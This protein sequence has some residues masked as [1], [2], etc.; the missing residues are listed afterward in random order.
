MG[1]H[2][3]GGALRMSDWLCPVGAR[4]NLPPAA[5]E[6]G[7]TPTWRAS[8]HTRHTFACCKTSIISAQ[9]PGRRARAGEHQQAPASASKPRHCTPLTARSRRFAT[10]AGHQL[11]ATLGIQPGCC[12]HVRIDQACVDVAFG[13]RDDRV[14]CSR[15][16]ASGLVPLVRQWQRSAQSLGCRAGHC[17]CFGHARGRGQ[18]FADRRAHFWFECCH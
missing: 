8:A 14:R 13:L 9:A 1:I 4:W 2:G 18:L 16:G 7:A 6:V 5:A 11:G 17:R 10:R 3:H 15:C 12:S